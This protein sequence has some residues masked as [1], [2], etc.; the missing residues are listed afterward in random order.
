MPML[1]DI[2]DPPRPRWKNVLMGLVI[3]AP[4]TFIAWRYLLSEVHDSVR[5]GSEDFDK[6]LRLE[7]AYMQALCEQALV[8]ERDEALCQCVFAAEFPSLDCRT[9]FQQ[10]TLA[11][12]AEQCSDA[13][14][15]RDALSFCTCVDVVE[16]DVERARASASEAGKDDEAAARRVAQHY[17]RCTPLPDALHLPAIEALVP[18]KPDQPT[19]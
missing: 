16:Q 4:V 11:R 15:R 13:Q 17:D 3:A 1:A 9:P 18:A 5:G 19:P 14:T 6:R 12:Q 8:L 2:D 10:W 7:D